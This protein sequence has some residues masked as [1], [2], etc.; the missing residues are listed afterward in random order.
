[1]DASTKLTTDL[2]NKVTGISPRDYFA[3][4][5]FKCLCDIR[6]Y[7]GGVDNFSPEERA[8]VAKKAFATADSMMAARNENK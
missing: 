7:G 5:V 2:E 3:G 6:C 1:M 8:Y 4:I